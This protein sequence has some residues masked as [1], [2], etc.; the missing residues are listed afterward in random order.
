MK[1]HIIS[2]FPEFV[3]SVFEFGVLRRA[4]DSGLVEHNL[5]DLRDFTHDKHRST[6][7]APFGGGPGMVMRPEPVFECVET[8]REQYGDLPL[9]YLS[10]AGEPLTHHLAREL[11]T[12]PD[13]LML[14][15]R[16]EGLDQRVI[17]HLVDRQISVGDYVLSGGELPAM[18]V[19]DAVSRQLPG[20]VGNA[21]SPVSD[22]FVNGLL[23]WPHYTRP[24]DFRGMA[25]PSVLLSGH[26]AQV[27]RW[28]KEQALIST[29]RNRPDLLTT[30][31][32]AEAERLVAK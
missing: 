16:Y 20:V 24:E 10:P 18:V 11:A 21:D 13:L 5:V 28:R 17:D 14:C 25:V 19:V 12:G 3:R 26:H 8:L 7:D 22:S 23:D 30:E 6:D 2:I 15:G 4:V 1:F 29:L 9:I 31:Q 32:R 27:E